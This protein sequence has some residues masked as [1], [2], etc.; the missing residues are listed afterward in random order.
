MRSILRSLGVCTLAALGFSP[1]STDAAFFNYL[2]IEASEGNSS[3]GHVAI[4]FDQAIYHFQYIDPGLIRLFKRDKDAFHFLYR[5]LQNRPI[6]VGRID[7]TDETY[8]LLEDRFKWRF[9][10]EERLFKLLDDLDRDRLFIRRVL[11]GISPDHLWFDADAASAL[12]LKGVGLFYPDQ[13]N[14]EFRV[15]AR[16]RDN[17]VIDPDALEKRHS[18]KISLLREKIERRLGADFLQHRR[19]RI[20]AGIR[21]LA[22]VRWT[23]LKHSLAG[24]ELP[25]P[26][27]SFADRYSD[28]LTA[29]FAIK[30][31]VE[32]QPLQGD[33]F[34]MLDQQ[35]VKVSGTERPVLE[36]LHRQL[37][38]SLLESIHSD[39]PDWGYAVIVNLA[40]YLAVDTSL[41]VGYWVFV[42]DFP[43]NAERV[44]PD[45]YAGYRN[46]MRT[47]IRDA[48]KN[49]DRLRQSLLKSRQLP[50]AQ[51]SQIELSAN[52]YAELLKSERQSPIRYDGERILPTK[53]IGFPKDRT[54]GFDQKQ[55]I[56]ALSELDDFKTQLI[57][58]LKRDYRYD[59]ISRNCVTELFG[60]IDEAMLNPGGF[61]NDAVGSGSKHLAAAESERR[62]GGHVDV[63]YNFIPFVS[64]QRVLERYHVTRDRLL[65]SYRGLELAR[66]K[67]SQGGVISSLKESNVISS[68]IYRYNP[69]D[70]LFLFFTDDSVVLRPVFG[71]FNTVAGIGQLVYGL[72][73]W[74]LD[75]GHH[76]KSGATGILMSLPELMF[77]NMRKGSYKYLSANALI[78]SDL[79]PE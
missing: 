24:H 33:A 5:Y 15:D 23:A 52:R 68:S 17:A 60:T 53:S 44:S 42:D 63:P 32:A 67:E 69:E 3:G 30:I 41:H 27:Y 31:F 46:H 75:T 26:V 79:P 7:V 35:A 43:D 39:R 71:A 58:K 18:R 34:F 12:K 76:L 29:W 47:L 78:D 8:R 64:Y 48:R 20:E 56:D 57:Q 72:L 55:L 65:A 70:A 45:R 74:P 1:F 11:H 16:H 62:L 28:Y 19:E 59:L 38:A 22:P 54:S 50:E 21:S 25:V 49:L 37:E 13:N 73:S 51:Y 61:G 2:Y 14:Q 10:R 66:R 77:F 9:L 40:R 6:H 4:Q 36:E